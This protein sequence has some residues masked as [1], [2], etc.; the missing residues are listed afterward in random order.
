MKHLKDSTL[1][2]YANGEDIDKSIAAH[3]ELDRRFNVENPEVFLRKLE[4]EDNQYLEQERAKYS[5]VDSL[6]Y[7]T[8]EP[9]E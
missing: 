5:E 3:K 6:D 4:D 1:W 2:K 8:H 7:I 9:R